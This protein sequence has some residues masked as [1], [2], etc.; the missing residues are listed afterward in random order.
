MKYEK[1]FSKLELEKYT[2]IRR[3]L[4]GRKVGDI[5][6]EY[7]NY[8]TWYAKIIKI[9][10]ETLAE[11][12]FHLLFNDCK[13][14]AESRKECYELFQSFYTKT[15]DFEKEPFF[16]FYMQKIETVSKEPITLGGD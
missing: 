7:V 16:I 15:I 2:T 6:R 14:F 11:I 10:Q 1:F 8:K 4:K 3:H 12:P 9:K 13:P 5:E